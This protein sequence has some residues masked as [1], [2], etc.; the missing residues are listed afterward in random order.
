[1]NATE[2]LGQRGE[3]EV[4]QY[5]AKIGHVI[6]ERNWR[7]RHLEIDIITLAVDGIHF[8]EVK[9]RMAPIQGDPEDAVNIVKQKRIVSAAS[10]YLA[11]KEFSLGKDMEIW[12][13]VAAVIFDGEKVNLRYHAGA[14]VPIYI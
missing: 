4:C 2:E 13:D 5:L 9:T 1:M 10:R 7:Y 8:V 3:D 14:F 6:L 11:K 12:F